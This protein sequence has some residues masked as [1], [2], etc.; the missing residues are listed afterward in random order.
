MIRKLSV[1]RSLLSNLWPAI[2]F[3]WATL[4]AN[5]AGTN[6]PGA[7]IF[8]PNAPILR[9]HVDIP[10]DSWRSLERD[11]RKPVSATVR[12]GDTIYTNVMVHVKGAA[13]SFRDINNGPSLTLSFGKLD[14]DQR[15]HGLRKIHINNSVQDQSQT[16]YNLTSGMFND[17]GIPAA[18]VTNARFWLNNRDLGM[19]VV[20]EGFSKEFLKRHFKD[21]KGNLY[22][23]GFL[24]EITDNLERDS[25]E[26]DDTKAD[27]KALA[28][29][30][31]FSDRTQRFEKLQKVLDVDR[32]VDFMVIEN[33]TWDWD[34]Y[35]AKHNNYRVYH[36]PTTGKMVFIPHGMDQMFWE[37]R[38]SVWRP[39]T[40]GLVAWAIM[41]TPEGAKLYR[42]RVKA[43]FEKVCR[44]EVLTNRIDRLTARNRPAAREVGRG[45]ASN[46]EGAVEDLRRRVIERW[47]FVKHQIE[48]EP[49]PLDFSKPVFVK[50]W[51]QQ[52]EGG[53]AR[54]D[55]PQLEDKPTLHIV[56]NGQGTASWRS[57]ILLE[58]GKY[59]FEVMAR[60]AKLNPVRDSKGEG[61]GIRISGSNQPRRNSISGDANWTKLT[62]D[63][64]VQGA[65]S[66]VVL[67]C[68]SR[69]TRG[70]VW[71]DAS[72]LKVEKIR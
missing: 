68:E 46:W 67:I 31:K 26:G 23:G 2:L 36:D 40:G 59:R 37:P 30:A 42:E 33:F 27:L 21:S 50:N 45:F 52:V 63:F 13:G 47:N 17:A 14:A 55:Q 35:M 72:A 16:T 8:A 7:D 4:V 18:R 56:S 71:F 61:A 11:A 43:V 10:K 66:E 49:K 34:G 48:N 9:I 64:E 20:V 28:A 38:G 6:N 51:R 57:S 60:A 3:A 39:E 19:Y 12:E 15:F 54:L 24:Q 70:E 1:S 29:A 25:G 58:P 44:L 69:A 32:F 65:S 22:D 62:Y 41:D 5:A 53:S